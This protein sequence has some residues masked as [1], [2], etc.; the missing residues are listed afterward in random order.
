MAT[1]KEVADSAG[2]PMLTAFQ[3]L[4]QHDTVDEVTRRCVQE[5]ADNLNY[6]LKITQIDIADLAGVAKGTV[7][8]ALNNSE[9][10]KPATRQK[11]L[12]AAQ[13]LGYHLNISA[14]NLRMNRTGVVGYSWH[15]A[16]DPSRMN[17][18]LDRFIYR[19]TMAAEER[20]F[21]LLTFVQPQKNA[22][23]V[24]ESL[25]STSRVDGFIISDVTY[26]D[27]R[28][29]RLTAMRAPFAAFGGMYLENADFAYVDVDGK[30]GIRLVMDHLL[31]QGHERIGLLGWPSGWPFG[32]AREASYR[33]AMRDAGVRI[34]NDWIAYT[35]NILD[36]AAMAAQQI[37]NS[38]YPP[39][40]LVCAN[41]L[42]A[43]GAKS[44]L[45]SVNLR[46]P[47]DVALT[48]Y[49]DDPTA[50]F[51][52]ITSVHQPIDELAEAL[53]EILLGDINQEPLPNR[54]I[55]FNPELV[56]RRSTR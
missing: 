24:Y 38:K 27:P 42:M 15:V 49:D 16:D 29:A 2:V 20:S 55:I 51:L 33:E 30:K 4:N 37:M 12:E 25:I 5:A 22:D 13:M 8:Y 44:Y 48:G 36:S 14:R 46:I 6:T 18:L 31:E 21:H 28:I 3:A 23:R 7:S 9:L 1:L 54:Q 10:I 53:F 47:D 41:D 17:N 43:F 52:G 35:H 45:D 34:E 26:N 40:A 11:V 19:V 56:I 39:T 50:Q 32:D